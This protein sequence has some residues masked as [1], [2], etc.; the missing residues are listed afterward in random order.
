M[1]Q[2]TRNVAIMFTD[3]EGYTS[4]MA[5]DESQTF[6]IVNQMRAV[7]RQHIESHGGTVVKELGDGVMAHFD[8]A[9]SAVTCAIDIQKSV[10]EEFEARLRIGIHQADVIFEGEDIFGDGVNIA[11]RIESLADP[12]GVFFSETV[13]KS[14]L[15]LFPVT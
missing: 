4:M 10:A 15:R 11:S 5:A 13:E 3:V 6:E 2:T 14:R 8:T 9:Q 7:Q 1:A 12:G